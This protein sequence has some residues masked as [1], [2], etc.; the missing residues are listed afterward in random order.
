MKDH[1]VLDKVV[2]LME[3]KIFYDL[4]THTVQAKHYHLEQGLLIITTGLEH[5]I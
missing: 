2:L 5:Q 3:I 4:L 1:V